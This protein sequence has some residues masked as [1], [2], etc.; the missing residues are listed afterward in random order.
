VRHVSTQRQQV[1][2]GAL[3]VAPQRRGAAGRVQPPLRPQR[4]RAVGL[5]RLALL[6]LVVALVVWAGA[7]VAHAATEDD[8]LRGTI[9]VVQPGDTLWSIVSA[10]YGTQRH[11][12]RELVYLVQQENDLAGAQLLPGRELHLPYVE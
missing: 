9:H 3:R 10:E 12:V 6:L 8:P 7:R 5:L 4:S 2:P 11:D 1:A